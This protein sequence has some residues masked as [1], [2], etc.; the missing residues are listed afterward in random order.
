METLPK[1]PWEA[2]FRAPTP[3]FPAWSRHAPDR[4]V[5]LSD[6][7][8]SYQAYAWDLARG[9]RR[10]FT[11]E[12]VG[13]IHATVAADGSLAVWFS[14]PTGDESGRW[15]AEPFDGGEARELLP[16]APVG[17]PDGLA[18]G[19]ELVVGVLADRD[20]FGVYVS[21]GG[22]PAKEVHRDVDRIAI[23]WS[24][25]SIEGFELGGLSA[26]ETLLCLTT[27]QEGDN[28]HRELGV[29]DPRTG[30]VVAE[31][32]DGPRL[33][34]VANAWSPVPGDAR[35]AIMHEREDLHRPA[36]WDVATGRRTD[37][38]IELP[39]EVVPV[40]WWPDGSA[41]L[42]IHLIEGRDELFRC[43]LASGELARIPGPPGEVHGAR[44]RP[45]GGVWFRVSSGD[46]ATRLLSDT[47]EELLEP[48]RGGLREGHPYRSWAF[49]NAKGDRVHGFLATPEGMGP[50]PLYLRVHGG[51]D[52][53]YMD[54]WFPIVDA[55]VDAGFAVAM[56]NYRGSVGYGTRWRDAIIGNIGF[57]EC[58][59]VVA[60][61]DDLVA[62]GVADP[63]RV[64]VGG[65]SW[66]GYVT[67]L[68][69]GLYP[70]RFAAGIAGVPVGDYA[71]SYDDSAPA[72]QA[73]DRSLIGGVVHDIPEFVRKR[74]P[75]T[76][77]DRARAPVLVIVGE[78]DT[79]CPPQQAMNWVEAYRARGGE[80]EVYAYG[81]GHSAYVVDEE[82]R[83]MRAILEFLDRRV[84]R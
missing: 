17:W 1:L 52:W 82:V 55:L 65:F 41:L 53:L 68:A 4:L 62:K 63:A 24:E 42:L 31:L 70:D 27:A 72:L 44:V 11:D 80:V 6:E 18:L 45:D 15:L 28:I 20:G 83:Q 67:L 12:P 66:G 35:L 29:L 7:S 5:L 21:E 37:L 19:R 73:F 25:Y 54:S 3:T 13:V 78:H 51:P 47:G 14:D 69:L 26:D 32:A 9:A 49:T 81:T 23:G 48:E 71:E 33:G 64:V 46:L 8:G 57:P 61:L 79:R 38:P 76:Y 2:R 36:I 22:G 16:G 60:G 50:F 59:D 75:I 40:D 34:L 84:P 39:G 77:V 56:V 58:E 30:A 74:S 43:D 10:R